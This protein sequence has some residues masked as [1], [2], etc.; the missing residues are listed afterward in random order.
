MSREET[1]SEWRRFG[2]SDDVT[3]DGVVV[4]VQEEENVVVVVVGG[5]VVW[6]R[7]GG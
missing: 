2:L 7:E 1:G 3:E 5:E 4:V 6:K